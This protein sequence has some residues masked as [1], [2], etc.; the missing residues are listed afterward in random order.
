M[1][2]LVDGGRFPAPRTNGQLINVTNN[3][4]GRTSAH[5]VYRASHSVER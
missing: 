1:H 4:D 3:T 2:V 5:S